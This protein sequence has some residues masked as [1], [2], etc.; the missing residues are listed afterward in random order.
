VQRPLEVTFLGGLFIIVGVVSGVAHAWRAPLDRWLVLIELIQVWAIVGGA[1]LIAGRAWARW[2]MVM[3]MAF[4][5]VVGALHSGS[6]AVSHG[7]LAVAITYFLF[8]GPAAAYFRP[9]A[10]E[11]SGDR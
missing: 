4:H 11:A 7:V 3:W 1:L 2:P 9:T 5:V 6:M 8:W 10:R